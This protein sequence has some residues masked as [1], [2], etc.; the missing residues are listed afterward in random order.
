MRGTS[1]IQQ[2]IFRPPTAVV[3]FTCAEDASAHIDYAHRHGFFVSRRMLAS[4]ILTSEH[5]A[6]RQGETV[7]FMRSGTTLVKVHLPDVA[8]R[9]WDEDCTEEK[10]LQRLVKFNSDIHG[11]NGAGRVLCVDANIDAV[12]EGLK[13]VAFDPEAPHELGCVSFYFL[14]FSSLPLPVS[15]NRRWLMG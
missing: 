2:F 14:L 11:K 3:I 12:L 9:F 5:L 7:Q 8:V 10:K 4:N 6:L 1:G 13:F 15:L